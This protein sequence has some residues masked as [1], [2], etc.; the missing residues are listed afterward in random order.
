MS[1]QR[2]SFFQ[3]ALHVGRLLLLRL[4]SFGS[5]TV[6]LCLFAVLLSAAVSG[7]DSRFAPLLAA[8][9]PQKGPQK[10][11][12]KR[13]TECFT[14]PVRVRRRQRGGGDAGP[15]RVLSNCHFSQSVLEGAREKGK[16]RGG[17]ECGKES[18][19]RRFDICFVHPRLSARLSEV[20]EE[21]GGGAKRAVGPF[22]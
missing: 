22:H 14:A 16:G 12:L 15:A 21:K 5:S 2:F 4:L 9:F 1:F 13:E 19:L 10:W 11:S 17:A 6:C 18:K 7:R 3:F 20:K 8:C